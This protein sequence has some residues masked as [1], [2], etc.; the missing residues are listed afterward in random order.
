MRTT[1]NEPVKTKRA[2]LVNDAREVTLHVYHSS[3]LVTLPQAGGPPVTGLGHFFRCTKTGDI[4]RWGFD[5][6]YAKDN[7]GN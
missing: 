5:V 4:R 3:Q 1:K 7:G 6:T 2:F